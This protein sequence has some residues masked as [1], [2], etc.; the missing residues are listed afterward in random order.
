MV[1][2]VGLMRGEILPDRCNQ[3]QP[4]VGTSMSTDSEID[5]DLRAVVSAG[6]LRR[7]YARGGDRHQLRDPPRL[8]QS[9]ARGP[10]SRWSE[11][12]LSLELLTDPL[13]IHRPA[14]IVIR[15]AT[16]DGWHDVE[17]GPRE[18]ENWAS[19]VGLSGTNAVWRITFDA[20]VPTMQ[21]SV[22]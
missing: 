15:K 18:P 9:A 10:N 6:D 22:P 11:D 2:F 1:C 13:A 17:I 21:I 16:F 4:P 12:Q 14:G 8:F 7:L 19:P 3:C 20:A 5:L